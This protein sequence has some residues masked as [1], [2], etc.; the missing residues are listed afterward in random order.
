MNK[1][2][3]SLFLAFSMMFCAVNSAC[4]LEIGD[5]A[6][7][8]GVSE[9]SAVVIGKA[10]EF[11]EQYVTVLLIKGDG[12]STDLKD[13]LYLDTA[14]ADSDG[15]YEFKMYYDGFEFE[16]DKVSNCTLKVK[17]GNDDITNTVLNAAVNKS[18]MLC[19]DLKTSLGETEAK[20]VAKINNLYF[21][22]LDTVIMI[23]AYDENNR[24]MGI[25][26]ANK[27][28]S[29]ET[30]EISIA[31]ENV[32]AEYSRLVAYVWDNTTSL[33]P[34]AK[35]QEVKY[36]ENNINSVVIHPGTDE[37]ERRFA[38]Y[39]DQLTVG[40]RIQ[41]ALKSDYEK[42]GFTDQNSVIVTGTTEI[43]Y[44]NN[45][46]ISCKAEIKNLELGKEYVYRIGN[47]YHFDD[48]VYS[49][50]TYD[51]DN[52]QKQVFIMTADLHNNAYTFDSMED[53]LPITRT[54]TWNNI[55]T[56]I[57]K[58]YPDIQFIASAGDNVSQGNMPTQFAEYMNSDW[59]IYR[60]KAELEMKCLFAPDVFQSIPWVSALGNHEASNAGKDVG[61]VSRWHYNLPNDN[62]ITGTY[63][64]ETLRNG[65]PN[66]HG[67][68]WFRNGDVLVVGINVVDQKTTT[69]KNSLPENNA[70]YI[71]SAVEANMDAKWKIL[72]NHTPAYSFI[73]GF[74]GPSV[75][76]QR[77]AEMD[78]DKYGFDAIFTGHQHSYSRSK[79][80][81]I[82]DETK[83][84]EF[85]KDS[86]TAKYITPEVVSEDKIVHSDDGN[87]HQID[88][89]T[90]PEGA[91]HINLPRL[92]SAGSDV[93]NPDYADY[94]ESAWTSSKTG[95]TFNHTGQTV[96][97][98]IIGAYSG[99]AYVAVTV[100]KNAEG[101]QMKIELVLS[102]AGASA[103]SDEGTVLDTYIIKKTN[104]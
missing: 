2:L 74:T 59:E 81:L 67:N 5:T 31:Y 21:K 6:R 49:F 52:A 99:N 48:N 28:I 97:D 86:A 25:A 27:E 95:N 57:Q 10:K 56:S 53:S 96:I 94:I 55:F 44:K 62:G 64:S 54:K 37:S 91:V 93:V 8:A 72:I 35:Q 18:E 4:A 70:E 34:Y 7:I 9:D 22:N 76:R 45:T 38:W 40:A 77:F 26:G 104:K 32:P 82:D 89:A 73:G 51:A 88:T 65:E 24:L 69:F 47:K 46:E 14:K 102:N 16:D 23:A 19:V 43:P 41:Y 30:D 1:K 84:V 42:Y 103:I 60:Q 83:Y 85:K 87:G 80:L 100:E 58:Q 68:F 11:A 66:T 15:Y 78:I 101:D 63:Y 92:Q 61:S 75:I 3:I 98:D 39:N 12:T 33:I 17:A 29:A 50:K 71:K 13:I 20:A 36:G 79:Q 90:N